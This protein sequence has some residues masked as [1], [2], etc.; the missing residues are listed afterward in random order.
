MFSKNFSQNRFI[1]LKKFILFFSKI[2]KYRLTN[3]P[4]QRFNL[5][6]QAQYYLKVIVFLLPKVHDELERDQI[7]SRIIYQMLND[8]LFSL[9]ILI[10]INHSFLENIVTLEIRLTCSLVWHLLK[11]NE[12][13]TPNEKVC[14]L[15]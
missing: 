1:R 14:C 10:K 7:L 3:V 15:I 13:L 4:H 12:Q 2:I 11:E 8:G 9:V 6:Q 5:F